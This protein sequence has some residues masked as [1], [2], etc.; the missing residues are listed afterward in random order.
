MHLTLQIRSETGKEETRFRG[1]GVAQVV[2]VVTA[3]VGTLQEG[4]S[5]CV[6]EAERRL[7]W[8][9]GSKRARE[10]Q[11]LAGPRRPY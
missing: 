9:D 4:G 5:R 11:E 2:V 7:V 3:C 1:F 10:G 8:L 6:R